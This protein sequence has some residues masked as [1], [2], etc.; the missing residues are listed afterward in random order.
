MSKNKNYTM[1]T[2]LANSLPT[3]SG[4]KEEDITFFLNNLES[5]ADLEKWSKEKTVIILKLLVKESARKFLIDLLESDNLSLEEIKDALKQKFQKRIEFSVTQKSFNNL[6]Q[7]PQESVQDLADRV[8]K[9]TSRFANPKN[10]REQSLKELENNLKLSKF[11]EAL[12]ADLRIELKKAGP[13]NFEQAVEIAKNIESAL[14]DSEHIRI[15]NLSSH[16]SPEYDLL[17]EQQLQTNKTIH[18]LAEKINNLT[19]KNSE[20]S[21]KHISKTFQNFQS[22]EV[23]TVCCHIC[24]KNHMTT[25][26]WFFP[27]HKNFRENSKFSRMNNSDERDYRGFRPNFRKNLKAKSRGNFRGRNYK[28]DLN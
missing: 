1:A 7:S 22:R 6:K 26:C 2:S 16:N 18:E 14:E 5:V 11:I 28:N 19:M 21:N 15:N 4:S 13:K 17:I 12:R 27:K 20:N 8:S 10:C 23:Q 3:F 9:V 24:F 25:D